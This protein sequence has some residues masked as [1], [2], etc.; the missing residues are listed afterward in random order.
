MRYQG[1]EPLYGGADE[2]TQE[3]VE[4]RLIALLSDKDSELVWIC[5]ELADEFP[6]APLVFN[7]AIDSLARANVI[8]AVGPL[9]L[10]ARAT[11]RALGRV[12]GVPAKTIH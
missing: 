2:P 3:S 7:D 10:L 11:G 5:R 4:A 12:E 9:V 8:H 1:I 6:D